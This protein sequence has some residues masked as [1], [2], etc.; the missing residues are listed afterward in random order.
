ML[1]FMSGTTFDY[2]YDLSLHP[3][4]NLNFYTHT[5]TAIRGTTVGR[6]GW[7]VGSG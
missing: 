2:E 1:S 3:G 6:H 5:A 4:G 7:R